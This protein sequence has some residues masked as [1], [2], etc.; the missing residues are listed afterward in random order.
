MP[1]PPVTD[2]LVLATL[3]ECGAN[4][5]RDVANKTANSKD[6]AALRALARVMQKQAKSLEN[7]GETLT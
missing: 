5:Y 4:Y 7:K 6:A 1:Y 2:P 3:L